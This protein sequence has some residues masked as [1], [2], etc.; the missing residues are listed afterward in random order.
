MKNN[1]E[2]LSEDE[3]WTL[4]LKVSEV[5]EQR[6]RQEKRLLENRLKEL[7]VAADAQR[8]PY[9]PVLPKYRNPESPSETWAG[10]GRQP[11]WLVAQLKSGRR[12]DDFRIRRQ[13]AKAG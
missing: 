12:L 13:I 11:R 6:I 1:L 8:R 4:R 9:P 2:H 5:L 7:G 10:R 3:L